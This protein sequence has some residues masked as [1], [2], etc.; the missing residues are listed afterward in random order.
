VRRYLVTKKVQERDA[1]MPCG[2]KHFP[3]YIHFC[4]ISL[5]VYCFY[6]RTACKAHVTVYSRR[7]DTAFTTTGFFN[8]KN[9]TS[10]FKEHEQCLAHRDSVIAYEASKQAPITAHLSREL[11]NIQFQSR[12]SLL[13]QF[14]SRCYLLRQGLA[15]QNDH[16]GGSNLSAMLNLALNES[17]WVKDGKY[18]SP[19]VVNEIIGIM[20][21]KV[22]QSLIAEIQC[23][24]YFS[25]I[26]DE[27]RD[28]S[29]RQQLFVC[30][31]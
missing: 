20:G 7:A 10:K 21:Q 14:I 9:A 13:N 4:C 2:T 26:T 6:C 15:V 24:R 22:L 19:Q 31:R 1:L 29:N 16:S 28:I 12:K 30:I 11:N 23:Q 27:T 8:W 3:G 5:K 25:L 17:S 18:E